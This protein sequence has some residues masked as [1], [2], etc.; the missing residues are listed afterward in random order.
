MTQPVLFSFSSRREGDEETEDVA[1]ATNEE[2]AERRF[3]YSEEG[4]AE[5]DNSKSDGLCW[6]WIFNDDLLW[7]IS[8]SP[9]SDITINSS[10]DETITGSSEEHITG[11]E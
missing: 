6:F 9:L 4:P 1:T 11:W 10:G 2:D 8:F 5:E 7:F 3:T